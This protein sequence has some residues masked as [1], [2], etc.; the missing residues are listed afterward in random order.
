M[1][2]QGFRETILQ[3]AL[4]NEVYCIVV[5]EPLDDPVILIFLVNKFNHEKDEKTNN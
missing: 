2:W 1:L 4:D 3:A 5:I